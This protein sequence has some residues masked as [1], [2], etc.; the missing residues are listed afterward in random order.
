MRAKREMKTN[1]LR[2]GV[3]DFLLKPKGKIPAFLLSLPQRESPSIIFYN[4]SPL[5]KPDEGP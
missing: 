2:N 4:T 5:K 3:A 1:S